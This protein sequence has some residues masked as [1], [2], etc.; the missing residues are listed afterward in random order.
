MLGREDWWM[1]GVCVGG[2]AQMR[3]N[4]CDVI[5]KTMVHVELQLISLIHV[6][7]LRSVAV[8]THTS[9]TS[10]SLSHS[11]IDLTALIFVT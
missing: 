11:V 3:G 2:G 4:D 7:M 9:V 5:Q 10:S 1:W 8:N 6:F